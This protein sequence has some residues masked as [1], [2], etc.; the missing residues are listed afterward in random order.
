MRPLSRLGIAAACAVVA[1]TAGAQQLPVIVNLPTEDFV[2]NWG[3]MRPIDDFEM[4]EFTVSGVERSFQCTAKGA[5][6]PG[7]HMRDV[8]AAREWQQALNGSIYF[9]QTA[10]ESLNNLYLNNDLQW[11]VLECIIPESTE[12]EE[13][14]QEDIDRALE[15][16]QRERE[17]RREREAEEREE[18]ERSD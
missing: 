13:D 17:R 7:S 5:F 2:W 9:I 18:A 12:S 8:Y 15:R 1:G 16:A 4:P 10:T 14:I 11:A 3:S 6:K